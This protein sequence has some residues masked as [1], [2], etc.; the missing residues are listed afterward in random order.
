MHG[1]LQECTPCIC[2]LRVDLD[3]P[4]TYSSCFE[5]LNIPEYGLFG[6]SYPSPYDPTSS[7]FSV[8]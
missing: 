4:T 6:I 7:E 1:L 3:N 2:R 8:P 5:L